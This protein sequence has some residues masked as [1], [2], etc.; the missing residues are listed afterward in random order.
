MP[1]STNGTKRKQTYAP[2]SSD[3]E[4]DEFTSEEEGEV[5][6]P[7]DDIPEADEEVIIVE[8]PD[9]ELTPEEAIVR[10]EERKATGNAFFKAKNYASATRLYT[11]AI[12]LAPTNPAYLTNRAAAYMSARMYT[13]ALA[14]CVSAA[15]LQISAPQSKTLLRLARCQ[16]ALGLIPVAQH[17]LDQL[18]QLDPSNPQVSQERA[19]ILRIANHLGNVK[20]ELVNKNWSMVLLG[21]DAAA[22]EIEVTPKEWRTWKVEALIGKKRYDDALSMAS[23]VISCSQSI[24]FQVQY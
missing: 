17:T 19:R 21:I 6:D 7:D 11:Q 3:E 20:R 9:S 1:T 13:Q 10:G 16:L 15:G 5:P 22:K 8:T 14:D 24:A 4:S 18:L 12:A 23:Y 2:P